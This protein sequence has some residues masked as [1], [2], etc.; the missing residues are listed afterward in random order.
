MPWINKYRHTLKLHSSQSKRLTLSERIYQLN[1]YYSGSSPCSHFQTCLIPF[2]TFSLQQNHWED[3]ADRSEQ[4][5]GE[6][7]EAE[8]GDCWRAELVMSGFMAGETAAGGGRIDGWHI[9]SLL[10][11]APQNWIASRGLW[12]VRIWLMSPTPLLSPDSSPLSGPGPGFLSL[13]LTAIPPPLHPQPPP[14]CLHLDSVSGEEATKGFVDQVCPSTF[15]PASFFALQ[16]YF[17]PS[18]CASPLFQQAKSPNVPLRPVWIVYSNVS[19]N[20]AEPLI[21]QW[22]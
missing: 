18:L 12:S 2:F 8:R 4:R 3:S 6:M 13:P 14:C 19:R 15:L 17:S 7:E 21:C 5:Q 9:I 20:R 22:C 1:L 16:C 11:A 10:I